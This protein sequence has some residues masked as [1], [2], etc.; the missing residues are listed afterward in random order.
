MLTRRKLIST[1]VA[2]CAGAV[3]TVGTTTAV[4]QNAT[5]K[6]PYDVLILGAGTAGLVCAIEAHDQGLKPVVLEKMDYAAGN[7]L[8]ASG[9]VAA[10]NTA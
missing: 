7:S 4:A 5:P 2:A 9:G 6:T 1:S 8:Y 3:A 10:F